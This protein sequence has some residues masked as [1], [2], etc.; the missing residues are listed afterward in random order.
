[1]TPSTI[2]IVSGLPVSGKTTI[3]RRI[4]A[5]LRLPLI[6][7]DDINERLF[8][9]LGWRDREWSRQL[10]VASWSLRYWALR[11]GLKVRRSCVAESNFAP[12][13]D[14]RRLAALQQPYPFTALQIHCRA[15]PATILARI[16]ARADGGEH[17]PGHVDRVTL[18][19]IRGRVCSSGQR[20]LSL[21]GD[22]L[23]VDTT[24]WDAVNWDRLAA[25][26]AGHVTL[27]ER[28]F[29]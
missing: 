19:E 27:D 16:E 6:S 18:A 12:A 20:P 8:D 9:N 26:A 7:R 24:D 13:T 5:E 3:A 22:C 28:R 1:V 2:I 10:G 14:T 4:A 29:A 23:T 11:T 15:D 17:H 25:F 21:P